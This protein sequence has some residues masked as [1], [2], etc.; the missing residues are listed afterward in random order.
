MPEHG[1]GM[2][3]SARPAARRGCG[4]GATPNPRARGAALSVISTRA[5]TRAFCS[6]T[7]R[8]NSK[9]HEKHQSHESA[10]VRA[11]LD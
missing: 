11:E 5:A 7:T 4:Q 1:D 8:T 2:M 9:N 3:S 10:A 6:R